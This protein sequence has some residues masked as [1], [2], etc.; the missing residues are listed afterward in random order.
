M[1]GYDIKKSID[2]FMKIKKTSNYYFELIELKVRK[3]L[4]DS[5]LKFLRSGIDILID[6]KKDDEE[7]SIYASMSN[8]YTLELLELEI[9]FITDCMIWIDNHRLYETM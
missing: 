2:A 9:K 5:R 8:K 7:R 6:N 1:H 3:K 4:L